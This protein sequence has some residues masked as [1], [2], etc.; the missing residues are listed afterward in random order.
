MRP[1]GDRGR[2]RHR[3]GIVVG[4]TNTEF[5][6]VNTLQQAGIPH[7][8]IRGRSQQTDVGLIVTVPLR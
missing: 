3:K 8:V 4:L 5:I 2:H 6:V 7:D 1:H